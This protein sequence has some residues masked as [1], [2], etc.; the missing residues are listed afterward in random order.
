MT[1]YIDKDALVAY[2]ERRIQESIDAGGATRGVYLSERMKEDSH[3]LSFI[4]TLEVKEV[5]L[6]KELD[7]WLGERVVKWTGRECEIL[8]RHFFE[9]GLKAV[10]K[11]DNDEEN[12]V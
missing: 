2:I 11:G 1:Q 10:Q 9:L 12:N 3:L 7:Y 5:D 6:E 4:D 8:C